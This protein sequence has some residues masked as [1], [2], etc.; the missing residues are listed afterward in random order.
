MHC[1]DPLLLIFSLHSH[2][3]LSFALLLLTGVYEGGWKNGLYAGVGT[4]SWANGRKYHGEW[5]DG[6][7]HGQGIETFSDGTLHHQGEWA[8]DEPVLRPF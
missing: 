1:F 2:I 6:M 8:N 3:I 7:A 4:C 5:K